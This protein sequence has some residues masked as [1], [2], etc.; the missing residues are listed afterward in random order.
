MKKI[1]NG[2]HIGGANHSIKEHR[3]VIDSVLAPVIPT[4]YDADFSKIPVQMQRTL[5]IC[6]A[7]A[8]CSLIERFRNDG[9][10]LSRRFMY[11]GMKK[12][13][14]G[15]LDE[16]SSV[17][18][19]LHFAY[20]YGTQPESVVPTDKTMSYADFVDFDIGTPILQ[21]DGKTWKIF[22]NGVEAT[23]IPGYVSVP[24]DKIS[25]ASGIIKYNGLVVRYEC[26][27]TWYTDIMGKVTWLASALFPLR[28]PKPVT[29][30]H[31]VCGTAFDFTSFD[32]LDIRNSWSTA[33]GL[34]GDGYADL[35]TFAP[36]EAWAILPT[37]PVIIDDT[38]IPFVK[39]LSFG[40]TDSEVNRLQRI[41]KKLGYM[42][43][44]GAN[45]NFYGKE[46]QKAVLA[47]QE[48]NG[49][50]KFGIESAF[51]YYFGVKSRTTLNLLISKK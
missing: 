10:V 24:T 2:V 7:E 8:T 30:G 51:G 32:R 46:T 25:L 45:T 22:T 48:Q 42:K 19:G 14:D 49:V 5:G 15:N 28:R 39:N 13:V 16:G 27:A 3:D 43:Y 21:P 36:T 26:G 4:Y 47:F 6:V 31:A 1:K 20:K 41:L 44:T 12:L 17:K 29:A 35:N 18:S 38:T 50:V 40:M 37:A 33:W 11:V 9:I 34:N 23:K